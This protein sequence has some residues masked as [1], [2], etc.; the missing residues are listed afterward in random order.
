MNSVKCVKSLNNNKNFNYIIVDKNNE[1]INIAEYSPRSGNLMITYT[2][3]HD[4]EMITSKVSKERSQDHQQFRD[5][6]LIN[7]LVFENSD[8]F[9][10]VMN[11]DLRKIK[12]MAFYIRLHNGDRI[13]VVIRKDFTKDQNEWIAIKLEKGD[14]VYV[15]SNYKDY[16]EDHDERYDDDYNVNKKDSNEKETISV[17]E[18][19]DMLYETEDDDEVYNIA[20]TFYD[21]KRN[22]K[23][24]TYKGKVVDD[25]NINEYIQEIWHEARSLGYKFKF[26]VS[27]I[28]ADFL[29][30]YVLVDIDTDNWKNIDRGYCKM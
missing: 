28:F 6:S 29:K 23:T 2:S 30:M 18:L 17:K 26:D 12:T 11:Y 16:D 24:M 10:Q 4:Y 13:E 20:Q 5:S 1:F 22:R 14:D 9:S 7:L 8:S 3:D 27:R 15:S 25:T 21:I 19:K